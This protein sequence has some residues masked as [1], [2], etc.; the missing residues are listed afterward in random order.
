M[1]WSG[2]S[3]RFWI[4]L[5]FSD[6]LVLSA[7]LISYILVF[8]FQ[9]FWFECCRWEVTPRNMHIQHSEIPALTNTLVHYFVHGNKSVRICVTVAITSE[10][11]P[12]RFQPPEYTAKCKWTV[13]IFNFWSLFY[14]EQSKFYPE[15]NNSCR[16]L[17][18][19]AQQ[20]LNSF[21]WK[22]QTLVHPQ[23]TLQFYPSRPYLLNHSPSSTTIIF[24]KT[25]PVLRNTG[26]PIALKPYLFCRHFDE[27][28]QFYLLPYLF[29]RPPAH[30]GRQF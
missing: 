21:F 1:Y 28:C 18:H 24:I 27:S 7:S 11:P 20:F 6:V 19:R 23:V 8:V 9:M 29:F 10:K 15:T 14:I 26:P 16:S 17:V 30:R 4:W 2:S 22:S 3:P 25:L 13:P 5:T 12:W